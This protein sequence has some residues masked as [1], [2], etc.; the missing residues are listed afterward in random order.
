MPVFPKGSMNLH[1]CQ[2]QYGQ[3]IAPNPHQNFGKSKFLF[4]HSDRCEIIF[5]LDFNIIDC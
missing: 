3:L 5:H 4:C 1:Y 2:L